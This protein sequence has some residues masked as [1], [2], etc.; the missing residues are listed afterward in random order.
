[1]TLEQLQ[2]DICLFIMAKKEAVK[3]KMA[4][5]RKNDSRP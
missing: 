5:E 3:T 1:M 2:C 4:L